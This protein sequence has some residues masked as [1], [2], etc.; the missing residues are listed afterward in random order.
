MNVSL[1]LRFSDQIN[2][3]EVKSRLVKDCV[4]IT[5][6]QGCYTVYLLHKIG[7]SNLALFNQIR[8]SIMEELSWDAF[9][10]RKI[11]TLLTFTIVPRLMAN[12]TALQ[13]NCSDCF[14]ADREWYYF[15]KVFQNVTFCSS[16]ASIACTRSLAKSYFFFAKLK[17][18]FSTS[19]VFLGT[20]LAGRLFPTNSTYRKQVFNRIA[21][22]DV[23]TDPEV[24]V[25]LLSSG[26][27]FKISNQALN[28]LR[29]FD[30]A[31][32]LFGRSHLSASQ[33]FFSLNYKVL[34]NLSDFNQI[35]E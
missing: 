20:A 11:D 34:K 35:I 14:L 33:I 13:L 18:M 26:K 27:E 9:L 1:A 5:N 21:G 16:P 24:Q 7:T 12:I 15:A 30:K 29:Q 31:S 8:T 3:D 32:I 2:Y 22:F 23:Q 6:S 28:D 25:A 4:V 10:S 17:V 19:T